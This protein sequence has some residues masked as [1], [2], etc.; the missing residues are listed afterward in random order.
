MQQHERAKEYEDNRVPFTQADELIPLQT[1]ERIVQEAMQKWQAS[2]QQTAESF[3]AT[4]LKE[5]PD[6]AEPDSFWHEA[7]DLGFRD[8]FSWGHDHDFGFGFKR[9]GAMGSRHIE[10]V[11][12][13]LSRGMLA[14]NL[15]GKKV[16]DIGCWSGGDLLLL[17][18]LGA[19]V[20]AIEEHTRSAASARRL[21]ELVGCNTTIHEKSLYHDRQDW[22]HKFD[23]IYCSGVIYHVTDPILFLRICFAY[24]KV[25]GSLIIETKSHD[26]ERSICS[27]SGS[28]EK[29][30][31]WFAP[32]S[33]A[34]GRWLVDA[35]FPIDDVKLYQRPIGRLLA[36]GRKTGLAPVAETAGFSRPGS[37][38]EESI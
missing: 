7:S 22:K 4:L 16:L 26:A 29:G 2:D 12:E 9:N 30:W 18:G 14:S 38:L 21:C 15:T 28:L 17:A 11:S 37:W 8:F 1:A 27:Y 5:F 24:L 33:E 6:T 20:T 31:N 35:G 36:Y 32:S 10:I 3:N 34:L 25:G 23:I 13:S 19:E